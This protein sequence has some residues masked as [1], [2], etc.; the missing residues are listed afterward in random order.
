MKFTL[1]AGCGPVSHA[2]K[3]LAI[4]SDRSVDLDT[5][6]AALLAPHDIIPLGDPA[7]IDRATIDR[8]GSTD[9]LAALAARDVGTNP[10]MSV[11]TLRGLLR[12]ALAKPA[13]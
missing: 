7:P 9:L 1:P 6:L 5:S 3:A 4:A 12:Q 13:R 10:Q 11:A 2:G 8:M